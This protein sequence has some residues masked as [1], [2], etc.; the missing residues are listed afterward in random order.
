MF[1]WETLVSQSFQQKYALA[2]DRQ[3]IINT[4]INKINDHQWLCMV[5]TIYSIQPNLTRFIRLKCGLWYGWPHYFTEAAFLQ[6][7]CPWCRSFLDYLYGR[8]QSVRMGHAHHLWLHA[9]LVYP[10][11]PSLGH[12][13]SLFTLLHCPPLL[14]PIWSFSSTAAVCRR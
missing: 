7:R 11:D 4:H 9:L 1:N 13:S 14:S 3:N 2:T 12:Y 5:I 8:T 10:K 6:F